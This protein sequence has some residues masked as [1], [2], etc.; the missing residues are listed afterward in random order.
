[1][2]IRRTIQRPSGSVLVQ[3]SNTI[4]FLHD[5]SQGSTNLVRKFYLEYFSDM[6]KPRGKFGRDI[7]WSQT[8]RNWKTWTRQTSIL[9]ESMHEVLKR[10]ILS[11]RW[12]SKIVRKRPRIPRTHSNVG[13]TCKERRS[14]WRT[15]RRTR[16]VST[17]RVKR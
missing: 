5:T 16:R 7:F 10:S 11:C 8:L 6:Q 14:Q 2:A 12:Y 1:M 17:D 4:R 3:S 13:T 9:E 15:S